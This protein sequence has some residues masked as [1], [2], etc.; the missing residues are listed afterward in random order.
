VL[1]H[2]PIAHSEREPL[3]AV[4]RRTSSTEGPAQDPLLP[5]NNFV[6]STAPH[7]PLT[8][9]TYYLIIAGRKMYETGGNGS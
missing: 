3:V 8:P 6:W 9:K 4:D 5:K 2:P 1:R 7:E